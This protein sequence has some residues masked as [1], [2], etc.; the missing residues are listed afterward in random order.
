MFENVHSSFTSSYLSPNIQFES[1]L[2]AKVNIF[3][4]E[5]R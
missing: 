5:T 2:E 3:D 4:A 1:N